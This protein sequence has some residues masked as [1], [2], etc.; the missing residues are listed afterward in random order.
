MTMRFFSPK[1]VLTFAALCPLLVSAVEPRT[2][3]SAYAKESPLDVEVSTLIEEITTPSVRPSFDSLKK[4]YSNAYTSVPAIRKT[5]AELDG[6]RM[7]VAEKEGKLYPRLT[8]QTNSGQSSVDTLASKANDQARTTT[9]A[10]DQLLYD[11]GATSSEIAAARTR[12]AAGIDKAEAERLRVLFS[13]VTAQLELQAAKKLIVFYGSN[14]KSRQQFFN[15][16]QEKLNLGAS[17]ALDLARANTKLLEAKA[18]IPA[19]AGEILRAE[20]AVQE[21][22][23]AVPEFTFAFYQQP[24][25][26]VNIGGNIDLVVSRHPLVLQA[27]KNVEVAMK[28]LDFLKGTAL[29]RISLKSSASNS[30]QPITGNSNTTSIFIEYSNTLFDGF[31]NIARIAAAR[32]K[33]AEFRIEQ[34]RTVRMVRQQL[35]TALTEYQS[36]KETL[37]VRGQLLISARKSARDLYTAFLLNRG[38]LTDIFDAEESYFTAAESTLNALTSV[39]RAYYKLLHLSGELSNAFELKL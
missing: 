39:Q 36:A 12:L 33:V 29:G 19:M 38:T 30:R 3:N 20:S 32:E 27:S 18:K 22:F 17:S 23:G 21:L 9:L 11:F 1:Y 35:L 34:E 7:G 15:L 6:L 14:E 24:D 25:V 8:L 37:E 31:S 4:I 26:P 16:I 10:A 5:T 28:E 13:M 2:W